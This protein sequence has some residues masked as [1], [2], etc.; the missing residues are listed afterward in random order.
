MVKIT[1]APRGWRNNNVGNIRWGARWQGLLPESKRTDKEFCQF[2]NMQYGLRALVLLL[3][4]Y[5]RRKWLLTPSLFVS[6]Y[7]PDTAYLQSNYVKQVQGAWS[8]TNEV[9]P[10]EL[11]G[12]IVR[13]ELGRKYYNMFMLYHKEDLDNAVKL[14]WKPKK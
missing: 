12:S 1:N 10:T 11:I 3:N 2:V 7:C 5:S 9:N 6:H 8:N 14:Y 13:V 4:T